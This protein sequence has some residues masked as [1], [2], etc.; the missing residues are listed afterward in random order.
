MSFQYTTPAGSSTPYSEYDNRRI[1][2]AVRECERGLDSQ[3]VPLSDSEFVAISASLSGVYVGHFR[4][5]GPQNDGGILIQRFAVHPPCAMLGIRFR[6]RVCPEDIYS[7]IL[8]CGQPCV[9]TGPEFMKMMRLMALKRTA[10]ATGDLAE[11]RIVRV[12]DGMGLLVYSSEAGVVYSS[13]IQYAFLNR[14]GDI[15]VQCTQLGASCCGYAIF[16]TKV[17]PACMEYW[18]SRN[19]RIDPD[20]VTLVVPYLQGRVGGDVSGLVISFAACVD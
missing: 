14:G 3:I 4:Y 13:F 12:M 7:L 19:P 1:M 18:R 20:C 17:F 9:T 10:I 8:R 16:H 15:L 11:P 2:F 5:A 6:D